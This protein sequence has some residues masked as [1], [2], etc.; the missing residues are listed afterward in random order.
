MAPGW[1]PTLAICG[2]ESIFKF[3]HTKSRKKFQNLDLGP[4]TTRKSLHRTRWVYE[5][6]REACRGWGCSSSPACTS[7][8]GGDVRPRLGTPPGAA[9]AEGSPKAACRPGAT[10]G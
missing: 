5:G 1:R 4:G 9:T 8:L 7:L 6:G 3:S 2:R 10:V